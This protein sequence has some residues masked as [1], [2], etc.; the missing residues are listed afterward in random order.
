IQELL[1]SLVSR[2]EGLGRFDWLPEL[3]S[4]SFTL[5]DSVFTGTEPNPGQARLA[6]DLEPFA[7]GLISAPIPLPWMRYGKSL[8]AKKRLVTYIT[9]TLADH[10]EHHTDT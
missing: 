8:A 10:R 4:L 2:W 3:K 9:S 1:E 5:A 6:A 7:S